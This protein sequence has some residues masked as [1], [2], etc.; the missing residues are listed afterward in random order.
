MNTITSNKKITEISISIILLTKNAGIT[1]KSVLDGIFNQSIKP[2]EVLV[3]DSGSKDNTLE[4]AKEYPVRIVEILPEDFR[5][6]QTRN[7][8]ANLANGTHVVYLTQDAIPSTADW[9]KELVSPFEDSNI[10]GVYG[11]QIP[12]KDE[13]I[14]DKFFCLSLYPDKNII[15]KN[16]KNLGIDTIFS[17]VNSA[18][19]KDILLNILLI[20]I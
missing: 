11:R 20:T 7:F 2:L 4:I 14:I 16:N 13:N 12:R 1:F 6:G 17:D 19:R 9:L 8:G 18:I 15:W 5:H 3:I 10:A